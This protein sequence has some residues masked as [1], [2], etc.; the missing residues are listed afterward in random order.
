MNRLSVFAVLFALLAF[1]SFARAEDAPSP[2]TPSQ[3]QQPDKPA[4]GG[5]EGASS[6]ARREEVE[7]AQERA[8]RIEK[9]AAYFRSK[10][11]LADSAAAATGRAEKA[12]AELATA[13]EQLTALKAENERLKADWKALEEAAL[14]PGETK[15]EASQKAAAAISAQVGKE[16]RSIGHVPKQTK[17]DADKEKHNSAA[18]ERPLT[19]LQ[20]IALGRQKAHQ[21]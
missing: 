12:E 17:A 21:N 8:G 6:P 15:T 18:Q 5:G 7:E 10:G 3:Q 9:M 13:R 19:A 11:G 20:L 2:G 16:L 4:Q 14:A 1:P